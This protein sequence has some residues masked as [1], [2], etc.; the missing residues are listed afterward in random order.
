[1]NLKSL[2]LPLIVLMS[3]ASLAF[4][5]IDLVWNTP[6]NQMVEVPRGGSFQFE[7]QGTVG[8]IFDAILAIDSSGSM[9]DPSGATAPNGGTRLGDWVYSSAKTIVQSLDGRNRLGIVEFNRS[10]TLHSGL[11]Q[12][13]QSIGELTHREAILDSLDSIQWRGST[14]LVR[15]LSTSAA[16]LWGAQQ[17]PA[18]EQHVILVTDGLPTYT[19]PN[20]RRQRA[21]EVA[22][23]VEDLLRDGITAVHAVAFPG[24]NLANLEDWTTIGNGILA[25]GT[26]VNN[27]ERAMEEVFGSIE[28]LD[29][30]DIILPDGTELLDFQPNL[31][32]SFS[33]FGEIKEGENM[34]TAR[35]ISRSGLESTATLTVFGYSAVPEPSSTAI[36]G[37]FALAVLGRRKRKPLQLG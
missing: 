23:K 6:N 12:L 9:N 35:A 10:A 24:A 37:L 11:F 19:D 7:A 28:S 22:N 32:G 15:P 18:R 30:L 34:F 26:D 2:I 16:A 8:G 31:D 4:G 21:S 13:D 3:P 33:I 29:R 20:G 27:L 14:N 17:D 1:M 5:Q 36:V 25:D